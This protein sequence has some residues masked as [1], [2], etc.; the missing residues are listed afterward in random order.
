MKNHKNGYKQEKR[1]AAFSIHSDPLAD[2]GSQEAGGQNIYIKYLVEELEKF[3]WKTDV[4]TR[5]DS[6]HKKQ[7]ANITKHSRV[8]RIKDGPLRYIP[9]T[10]LFSFLPNIYNGFLSF[11]G[12]KNPYSLF[13][14][15]YWEGGW[16]AQRASKEF[17]K[18]LVQNFHSLGIVRL[19]TKKKYKKNKEEISYFEKRLDTEKEVIENASKI[20]SL[21]VTEKNELIHFYGCP[22]EK[23]AVIPG[24]INLKHWRHC[25]K[26]EARNKIRVGKESF[27]L[28]YVGRL[29]WRK[30]IGTLISACNFLRKEIP[31]LHL[32]IVGGK[33]FGKHKNETDFKEQQKL[34]KKADIEGVRDIVKFVGNINHRRLPLFYRAADVFVIPSYYEPFGLVTLEGMASKTPVVASNVGGLST[35]INDNENGLLFEPRNPMDLKNKIMKLYQSEELRNRLA[36]RAY[37]DVSENYS[38]HKAVE[39]I[40][41]LYQSL[42]K[43]NENNSNSSF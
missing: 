19:E 27:I 17:S 9:K 34:Q 20:I 22:G 39:K 18:P 7:I 23:V 25:S 38:W 1:V 26:E 2:L 41:E 40:A 8:I 29:E 14:G 10:E 13:H 11:I 30:G 4:F 43:K 28:L 3:G 37:Q 24:G 21:S 16:M 32:V 31:N 35:I 12:P 33:L 5:W 15:H 6:P 36:E 42:T